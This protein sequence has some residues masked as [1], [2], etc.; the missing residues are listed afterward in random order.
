MVDVMAFKV[1]FLKTFPRQMQR[2]LLE[3]V[4][5]METSCDVLLNSKQDQYAPAVRREVGDRVGY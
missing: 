5:I 2:Q 1:D 3:G 4:E